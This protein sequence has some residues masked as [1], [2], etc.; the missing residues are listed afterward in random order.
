MPWLPTKDTICTSL[1][2][3]VTSNTNCSCQ[4]LPHHQQLETMKT[5]LRQSQNE[6]P[7]RQRAEASGAQ[8]LDCILHRWGVWDFPKAT[9]Q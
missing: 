9:A 7:A 8:R 4:Y 1:S 6:H 2:L 5:N 3:K